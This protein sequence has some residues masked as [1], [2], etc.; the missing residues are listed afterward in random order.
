MPSYI[1]YLSWPFMPFK[2]L[3]LDKNGTD[4]QT[5]AR[6]YT[7]SARRKQRNDDS[8]SRFP[9][10]MRTNT[11]QTDRRDWT[12]Y[13]TPAAI[14]PAWVIKSASKLR[15]RGSSNTV[16]FK[17][18][19]YRPLPVDWLWRFINRVVFRGDLT[20]TIEWGINA[21]PK[22]HFLAQ[23]Y[24]VRRIDR[25]NSSTGAGSARAEE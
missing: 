18:R 20:P 15:R 14:Q 23:K 25:K 19:Y 13:S 2:G 8:S 16:I 21:T 6:H 12:P 17:Q 5:D 1:L 7:L 11:Q 10:R 9:F 22:R 24:D 3:R 4:G